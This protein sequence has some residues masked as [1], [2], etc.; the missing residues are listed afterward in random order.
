MSF[1]RVLRNTNK[2][3]KVIVILV[4]RLAKRSLAVFLAEQLDVSP[5]EAVVRY[6]YGVVEG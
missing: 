2:R 5:L 3:R 6:S 4:D 1:V